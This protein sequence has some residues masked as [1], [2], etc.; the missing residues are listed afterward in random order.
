LGHTRL[1]IVKV[2]AKLFFQDLP[3]VVWGL[4]TFTL[5]AVPSISIAPQVHPSI[6]KKHCQGNLER[7]ESMYIYTKLRSCTVVGYI[8]IKFKL[9]W[10]ATNY[11]LAWTVYAMSSISSE[12]EQVNEPWVVLQ[13]ALHGP[14]K[15]RKI[16]QCLKKHCQTNLEFQIA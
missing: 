14:P 11:T 9:V 4:L 10:I 1:S 7:Q 5:K 12:H 8:D 3:Q 16:H 2:W 13:V 15:V 6:A